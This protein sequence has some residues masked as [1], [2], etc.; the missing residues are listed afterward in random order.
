MDLKIKDVSE[1]LSVSDS[2]VRRWIAEGKIPHYRINNQIYFSR[3]EIEDWMLNHGH[4]K[5]VAAPLSSDHSDDKTTSISLPKKGTKQF[6]LLRAIHKGDVLQAI[7]GK[8][9]EEIIR[10]TMKRVSKRIG[11][12][13]DVVTDLLL[14]R[15]QMMA[16]GL[17][18][19]IGV[20][21]T[22]DSLLK[23]HQDAIV[24]VFPENPIDYGSLDQIPVHTL[25]FLFACD[26]KSHLNLLARIAHLS[27]QSSIL[28]ELEKKPGKKALLAL[29]KDWEASLV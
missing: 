21:H 2:T 28:K 8:T 10:E 1:L 12:D 27:S 23:A 5:I 16:T 29:I 19:G 25:F 13:A 17:N 9:K 4:Q 11:L 24:V 20:P 22:R 6:S 3:S 15:E 14:D 7:P 18:N 26:D